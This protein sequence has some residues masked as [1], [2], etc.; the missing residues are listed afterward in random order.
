MSMSNSLVV[1]C[2]P[3][4]AQVV[5]PPCCVW[6]CEYLDTNVDRSVLIHL[7]WDR[8]QIHVALQRF[9]CTDTFT[10]HTYACSWNFDST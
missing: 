9:E 10:Y 3:S 5:E 6:L 7:A 8:R 4:E 1:S 2:A